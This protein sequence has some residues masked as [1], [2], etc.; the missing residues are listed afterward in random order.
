MI[1]STLPG[2]E[3]VTQTAL[4]RPRAGSN[5]APAA[6]GELAHRWEST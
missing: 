3:A 6:N 4:N 1:S 5:P 2:G